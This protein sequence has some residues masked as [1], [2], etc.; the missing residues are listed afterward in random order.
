MSEH[1]GC[2]ETHILNSC[3]LQSNCIYL[4]RTI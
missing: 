3:I 2:I 1:A 4:N